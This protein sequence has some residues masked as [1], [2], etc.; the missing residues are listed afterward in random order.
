M[1]DS[2]R[3]QMEE[4]AGVIGRMLDDAR[5]QAAVAAAAEAC[6][7]A[8]RRGNKL[9]FMGNGGSAAD[10]QHLAGEMVSRFAF[11]R[12]GLT[13]FALT[14]DTSVL[15]AIGNDYG[16]ELLFARQVEAVG[17]AGD[18]L[19]G[20][21]TSGNSPNILAGLAAARKIGV[22]T[23]GMTGNRKAK[24]VQAVDYCIEVPSASTPK[25]QE[26]HIVIGHIICGLVEERM[27]AREAAAATT[28]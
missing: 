8:L 9:L 6:V 18:V 24:I 19:F 23:V 25:I 28:S 4:S 17:R 26:G 10:C 13:A 22:V 27:F 21:S 12:P 20:L 15:T 2:I 3:K 7:A 5:L 14:V 16:Y 1:R 11:D